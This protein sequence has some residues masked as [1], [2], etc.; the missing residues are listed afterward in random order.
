MNRDT[1][2]CIWCLFFWGMFVAAIVEDS[3]YPLSVLS[4]RCC[5]FVSCVHP[6]AVTNAAFCKICSF[7]MP[8]EDARIDHMEDHIMVCS[9]F[10]CVCSVCR[11]LCSYRVL[12]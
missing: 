1:N 10:L 12:Q 5:M 4:C 11:K 8:V 9:S 6:V 7:L 3:F 2:V